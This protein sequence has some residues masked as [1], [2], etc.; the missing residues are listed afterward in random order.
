MADAEARS[1]LV[2]SAVAKNTRRLLPLLILGYL[3][4]NIDRSSV[5]I[6]ALQMNRAIGLSASQFGWGAG[7]LFVSYCVLEVPSNMIMYR[8]G[9]RRWF[10]RIM[11]TWGLAAASTAFVVGPYSFYLVRLL[12]GAFESG[13]FPG[14]IWYLSIW[15]P[16]RSRT[17]ALAWFM[18][19]TPLSS[20]IGNP[21]S[22]CLLEL[23]GLG[24]L[25]GWQ[26]MFLLEGLPACLL[27]LLCFV[28]LADKPAEA[29]WLTP[30]EREA[31]LQEL[32]KEEYANVKK[33][34]WPAMKDVRVLMLTGIAFAFTIGSFGIGIWLPLILKTHNLS[35]M[36]VGWLS[37][38]PY[39]FV[40]VGMLFWAGLV[41]R[42]GYKIYNLMAALMLGAIGLLFS[43][44]LSSL[45]TT[46]ICLTL[47]LVGT[48]SARTILYTMPQTFLTG[49]AAA[50]GIAFIN[51]FGAFGAFVGPYMVGSLKDATGSFNAGM[52]GMAMILIVATSMAARLREVA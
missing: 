35:D 26:W 12:L 38:V 5:G 23:D 42:K 21:L 15:F 50:G 39:L 10:A 27:G 41:D 29:S 33:D 40:S 48:I 8:F 3:F 30:G 46:L 24:G 51:S 44:V 45:L 28:L 47:A 49:A 20:L 34:V 32:A 9:A 43:A 13:F 25:A 36:Q 18:A 6:A 37:A 11:I 52:I 19:A 17:R 16:V 14:V 7:I 22:A 4:N 31:L 2:A 1:A